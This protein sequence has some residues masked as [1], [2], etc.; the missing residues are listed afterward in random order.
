ADQ[1]LVRITQA[2]SA[3]EALAAD[4]GINLP[5]SKLSL[6][7]LTSKDLEDLAFVAA[8][9]DIVELS[10]ANSPEDVFRLRRQLQRAG[11]RQPA[12]VLKIETRRGFENLPSMLI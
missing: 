4:K 11:D 1:I 3:G 7:A 8:N 6:A 9:A 10:F 12:I 5:D 2:S